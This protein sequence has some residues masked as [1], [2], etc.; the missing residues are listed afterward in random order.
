MSFLHALGWSLVHF[1][2][3]GAAIAI[4]L[5][6][7][8][9][10]ARRAPSSFRYALASGALVFM[11]VAPAVT[12]LRLRQTVPPPASVATLPAVASPKN[13]AVAAILDAASERELAGKKGASQLGARRG[14]PLLVALRAWLEPRL[15]WLVGVWAVGVLILAVR[16]LGGFLRVRQ[17]ETQGT[18]VV[19]GVWRET[20][21]R[22]KRRLDV[23]RHVELV[24][25][26][27]V[28]VP[29]VI[30]WVRPVILL[31]GSVF[32]GL[33][34]LQLE[35]ILVHEL[36]HIRRHDYLVNLVQALIETVLFYHPAVWWVSRK[37][38]E[39]REHCCDD[40]AVAACGD[41]RGYAAALVDMER[42]RGV[43][44]AYGLSAAGGTLVTRVRRLLAPPL[45]PRDIAPRWAAGAGALAVVALLALGGARGVPA[46]VA[47]KPAE[48]TEP[49]P[50]KR[51]RAQ[52][53]AQGPD[54]VLLNS[55]PALSWTERWAWAERQANTLARPGYWIG[56]SVR[57]PAG[58]DHPMVYIDPRAVVIGEGIT[59]S[60]RLFGD[61]H[62]LRFPGVPLAG[63]VGGGDPGRIKLLFEF[64]G[65]GRLA[66]IHASSFELPVDLGSH[67]LLW[68]GRGDDSGSVRL[69]E[70]LYQSASTTDLK[71]Q[72]IDALG[73]HGASELVVPALERRLAADEP[74][75]VRAQAAEWLGAHAVPRSLTLLA[76]AARG[77]R[78][79]E[80]RREAAE[81]VGDLKLPAA[82][83][84]LIALA[85]TLA[86]P[87]ARREAV[88]SLGQR[89]EPQVRTA[90]EAIAREDRRAEVQREA[91]ETL[92]ELADG[93]GGTTLRDI[94]RT[95]PNVDVRREA[96]ETVGQSLAPAEAVAFLTEMA[97]G[98]QHPDVQREAV[99]TLG[100]VGTEAAR[101][102]VVALAGTHPHPDVRRE[103][104]ETLGEGW[105]GDETVEQLTRLAREDGNPDV[106]REAVETLGEV[107]EGLGLAM[108]IDLAM[109]HRHP[110]VR[111]EAIETVGEH[112]P[113]REALRVLRD[114]IRDDPHG[115]VRREAVETL[116]ALHDAAATAVLRDVARS[117]AD[118]EVRRE[119][120]E[121][122]GETVAPTE[123]IAILTAI[124]N[125]D[126]SPEVQHEALETLLEL[127]HDGGIAAVIAAARGHKS[128]EVRQ[129]ALRMLAE[130]DDPRA[131]AIF[132]RALGTP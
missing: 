3:Q 88:E 48:E 113:P 21:E 69:V 128:R 86:D 37:V 73:I 78:S 38:R 12:V 109:T 11:I 83:D 28:A 59:L 35:S 104:I 75:R 81:A 85:R 7:A 125:D 124:L 29:I 67:A 103:A 129:A 115:D 43:P 5:A 24:Q 91:V 42:L 26:A 54:T 40:L 130:S 95:H 131:R 31:P 108:V 58:L 13:A 65:T 46:A 111:R 16:L 55:D 30:G 87:E 118:P 61:F 101:A 50:P 44:L 119:A 76:G 121:T 122:I 45:P 56:Y 2:W 8:L 92:G 112:A 72:A 106:Q 102:A 62:G 18:R 52:Q 94:A 36:A 84:T 64:R 25:S 123:A 14:A 82:T 127:H 77:D 47:Q 126:A 27:L 63:L 105:P 10:A 68:L 114:V 98:D 23:R 1:V 53:R 74:G 110:D 89:S 15:G 90:L 71:H 117:H 99:E 20:L 39:A 107:G 6:L 100:E 120:V 19:V 79:G 33:T 80:V 96:I 93:K 132:E 116:G 4:V 66:R 17:L 70:R 9:A 49:D 97:R 41:A 51:E 22:L 57:P 32:T 60:G 34:P